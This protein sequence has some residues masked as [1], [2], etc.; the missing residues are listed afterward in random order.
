VQDYVKDYFDR[1]AAA[2]VEGAYAGGSKFPV[3]P[4]R[5]RLAIE[6]VAPAMR[7]GA[8]LA[9]LG[10]GGGQLCIHAARLGWSATGVDVAPGMIEEA[11]RAAGDLSVRFIESP[12]DASGLESGAFDAVTALG[13]IEYL[14]DDDGLFAEAGRLLRPGGSLAVSC[15]NRLYNVLSANRYTAREIE[16]GDAGALLAE[17][18]ETLERTDASGLHALAEELAAAASEL[19]EAARRD[20]A[21]P[22]DDLLDHERTFGEERRQHTPAELAASAGRHGFRSAGV[23]ALH[24]HPLPPDLERV[25]PRFYNR[26][27]LVWQRALER[28]PLGLAHSSAFVAVFERED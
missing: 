14:P 15:R 17:L 28:S 11:T 6:G 19:A 3:G 23:L 2:W 13:L 7:E 21:E 24:P 9:D 4:E 25:S 18:L 1:N 16:R 10:C 26:L 22:P 8:A 27:A 12:Y 5:V 20:A